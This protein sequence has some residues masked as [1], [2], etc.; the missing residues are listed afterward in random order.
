MISRKK[1]AI[2][3]GGIAGLTKYPNFIR[4]MKHHQNS[5]KQTPYPLTQ[6]FR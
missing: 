4:L 6:I 2:I 3:G 5:S 1:I